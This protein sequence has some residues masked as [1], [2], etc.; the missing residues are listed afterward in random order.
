VAVPEQRAVETPVVPVRVEA[1]A[2]EEGLEAI[3]LVVAAREVEA[4]GLLVPWKRCS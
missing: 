2:C 4:L 1:A 3:V